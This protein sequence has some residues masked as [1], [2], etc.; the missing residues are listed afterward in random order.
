MQLLELRVVLERY[1][2]EVNLAH[3]PGDNFYHLVETVSDHPFHHVQLY[4]RDVLCRH[5]RIH[6]V[7]QPTK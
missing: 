6:V 2:S 5:M 4:L 1:K 3:V 7:M